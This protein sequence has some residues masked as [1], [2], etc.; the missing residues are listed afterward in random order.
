[1]IL[2]NVV[3]VLVIGHWLINSDYT[4]RRW[5]YIIDGI[6]FSWNL[7]EVFLYVNKLSGG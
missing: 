2:I 5:S 1:M 3:I 4:A 6:I 7:A